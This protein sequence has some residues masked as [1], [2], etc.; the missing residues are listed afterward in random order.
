[1]LFVCVDSVSGQEKTRLGRFTV[2]FYGTV[3]VK[4]IGAT[5][6]F[7]KLKD[8]WRDK[9]VYKGDEIVTGE[10]SRAEIKIE[11]TSVE[12]L[13][14]TQVVMDKTDE[15]LYVV[16][17][18]RG[19]ITAHIETDIF[20][21]RVL[22]QTVY[23]K[24]TSVNIKV[25]PNKD[26]I[27]STLSKAR[28]AAYIEN[29]YGA[30]LIVPPEQVVTIKYRPLRRLYIFRP[31]A[32]NRE[33]FGVLPKGEKDMVRISNTRE[34]IVGEDGKG[35]VR[36]FATGEPDKPKPLASKPVRIFS[37]NTLI[38][39]D[40]FEYSYDPLIYGRD[41]Y[42]YTGGQ[43]TFD[44]TRASLG[45]EIKHKFAEVFLGIDA[46]KDNPLEDLWLKLFFPEKKDAICLKIGQMHLPFGRQVQTYPQDLLLPEYSLAV[47]YAFAS[48]RVARDTLSDPD[49]LNL[50]YLNSS[51]L[52]YLFDTGCQVCGE[53]ELF[54]DLNVQYS[55]GFFNGERRATNE[56]NNSK[57]AVGRLGLNFSDS[58]FIGGSV[59]DGEIYSHA[60]RISRRRTGIDFRIDGG[61]L[62]LQ[63]EYIWA[64]DNPVV[65]KK[66][67]I[68]EGYYLEAGLRLDAIKEGWDKFTFIARIDLL[69][70]PKGMLNRS[71]LHQHEKVSAYAFGLVWKISDEVKF[72]A[73][74]ET[75]DQ[76]RDRYLAPLEKAEMDQRAIFQFNISF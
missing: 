3:R 61:R 58:F 63:G 17:M 16:H 20:Q 22:N 62:T 8:T 60:N 30:I 64:E 5:G 45:I 54:A 40:W 43:E 42:F 29:E 11:S 28:A 68:T 51:D 33:D 49:Y 71:A 32:K 69:D 6:T 18:E 2:R 75:L 13:D 27:I 50:D 34:Y 24:G 59:Y 25:E 15:G 19:S 38:R 35:T 47:K 31:S 48:V 65:G 26:I 12:L 4:E 76:G 56:T 41:H 72:T 53:F 67:N 14:N 36:D 9:G 74:F 44:T 21:L 23:G 7:V 10:E 46:V 66:Y 39:Y 37:I 1:M 55:A 57:A 70:P 52:D 73:V